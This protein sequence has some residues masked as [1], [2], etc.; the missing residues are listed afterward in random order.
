MSDAD[1]LNE[2]VF[3]IRI[4]YD[5]VEKLKLPDELLNEFCLSMSEKT[6]KFE[7]IN[8]RLLRHLAW[9]AK[10]YGSLFTTSASM[11]VSAIHWLFSP[12]TGTVNHCELMTS[13]FLETKFCLD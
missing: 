4:L 2:L 7:S 1:D 13:R 11:F 10:S 12:L 5:R 9:Q 6:G 3:A 8:F